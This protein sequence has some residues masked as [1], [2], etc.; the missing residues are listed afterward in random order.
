MPFNPHLAL[1]RI[2][3]EIESLKKQHPINKESLGA[4][5]VFTTNLSA[6]A[7]EQVLQVERIAATTT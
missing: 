5:T 7:R 1:S 4:W 6:M 3:D 2:E